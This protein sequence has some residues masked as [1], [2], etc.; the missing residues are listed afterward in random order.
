MKKELSMKRTCI[1]LKAIVVGVTVISFAAPAAGVPLGGPSIRD[2][3]LLEDGGL[4]SLSARDATKR[5]NY[6]YVS[7][8]PGLITVDVSD[9][10]NLIVTDYWNTDDSKMNGSAIKDNV[11]YVS[12][13][14]KFHGVRLFDIDINPAVPTYLKNID[15]DI[16]GFAQPAYSWDVEVYEDLLYVTLDDQD[17]TKNS[18]IKTF[19]ISDPENPVF[20]H[21]FIDCYGVRNI[22]NAVRYGNYLYVV[23]YLNL[24]IYNVTNPL[25]PIFVREKFLDALGT[26]LAVKGDYLFLLANDDRIYEQGGLHTYLL[27]GH[28]DNPVHKD[29]W[30]F[31]GANDMHIQG[32]YCTLASGSFGVYTLNVSDPENL[33]VMF[34]GNYYLGSGSG[35]PV[36]AAGARQGNYV[37]IGT[38][39]YENG[40]RLYA[41]KIAT[42]EDIYDAYIDLGSPEP[43]EGMNLVTVG[44][45]DTI[46]DN[47]GG[48]SCRRNVDPES[49]YYCYFNIDDDLAYQGGSAEAYITIDY[50]DTDAGSL[51]LQ[52][53]AAGG[54][55]TTGG[56]VT[57]TGSNIWKQHRFHVTDAYFGN[58]QNS[59]ADFRIFK[60]NA[61]DQAGGTF[62]LDLV[63]ASAEPHTPEISLNKATMDVTTTKTNP[64]SDN[65]FTVTNTGQGMLTYEITNDADW[66]DISPQV[67]TGTGESDT[68]DISYDLTGMGL[69]DYSATVSVISGNA[70]N[71]PQQ[72]NI[73]L[74]IVI[75]GDFEPADGDVDQE[76]FGHL[77][78]C[79]SGD[80]VLY[81]DGC[82]DADFD[83]DLDVDVEDFVM[84]QSCM[85]GPGITPGC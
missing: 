61:A 8:K 56:F 51:R 47:I 37:Y 76:D 42:G 71:S 12:H 46:V 21:D 22:S 44:D 14:Y 72:I 64:P 84:F 30:D 29:Y 53:D 75:Y 70:A 41:I 2:Y 74:H 49:D 7:G 6:I 55:Y 69:G 31:N 27:A 9:P 59:G 52:Y 18:G 79:F 4:L 3:V 63:Q 60:K 10:D 35:Y 17:S 81:E 77:Q 54:N 5:G 48:R 32:D 26:Q 20:E 1:I 80:G 43:A 73:D 50:Y 16:P 78:E 66:L 33:T 25:H 38:E 34:G 11:L 67:G 23:A 45:G 68:I 36:T 28:E 58:R 57:L 40:G 83:G 24:R 65:N 62:Y 39:D 19:D 85:E 13:W 15:T 82:G